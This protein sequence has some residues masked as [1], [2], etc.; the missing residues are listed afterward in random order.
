M[1]NGIIENYRELREELKKQGHEFRS[2]T[3]T[4]VI[5]HLVA[6]CFADGADTLMVA[7]QQAVH[8]LSGAFAIAVI[9]A[10][11]PDEIILAR[12]QAPLIIGIGE[13]EYFCASDTPAIVQYTRTILPLENGEMARLTRTGAELY[14]FAG[15]PVTRTPRTIAWNPIAIEKQG[16]RH[17]MAKEIYEQPAVVRTCL[18][19]YLDLDWRSEE[20]RVGKEC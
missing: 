14:T 11:Y 2:E 15:V 1:Q 12:Q 8:K 16:F 4:E 20:R 19:A 5:P 3:D 18:E 10:D 17:F 7:V 6:Q 9:S 13:G